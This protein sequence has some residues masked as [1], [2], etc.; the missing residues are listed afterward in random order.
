MSVVGVDGDPSGIP[1]A[2]VLQAGRWLL[3]S[4]E[5]VVGARLA[6]EKHLII[7]DKLR[8][9]ERDFHVVG[10]GR[11]RGVGWGSDGF[12]YMDDRALR[13]RAEIGDVVNL[14]IADTTQPQLARERISE[15]NDLAIDSPDDLVQQAE[16]LMQTSVVM[17][18]ILIGLTLVIAGLFVA[19]MLGR[20]VMARR[21]ELATL[22][23]IGVPNRTILLMIAG[24]ALL[25]TLLASV[26]GIVLSLALGWLIDTF[27]APL[28]GIESLYVTD[29]HVYVSVLSIALAL[30]LLP[31]FSRPVGRRGWTPVDVLREA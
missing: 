11:L 29:A 12:A 15:L 7:G 14:V 5:I 13:Q 24:E 30:G 2:V 10:V 19:N 1:G 23:A 17:Q 16:T 27:L 3:R 4:D 20:S 31:A 25:V 28:Y 18:A 26:V 9:N 22:R 8:L 6:R 21:I